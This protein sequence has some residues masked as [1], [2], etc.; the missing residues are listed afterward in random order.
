MIWD[1]VKKV[2]W[3]TVANIATSI[4]LIIAVLVFAWEVYK[5]RFSN[6]FEIFNKLMDTYQNIRLKSH[7]VWINISESVR[8]N[9]KTKH[10]LPD[11]TNSAKYLILRT[12]QTEPLYA[13]EHELVEYE[14]QSINI[15][16]EICKFALKHDQMSLLTKATLSSEI[17]FYQRNLN[18]WITI[19]KY[20]TRERT[21]SKLKY[22]SLMK[23]DVGDFFSDHEIT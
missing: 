22:E 11:K 12:K 23:I 1:L 9:P 20:A 8:S 16:N 4:T 5:N 6:D 18:D 13:I 2:N 21:L 17:S 10:E 3:E 19:R 14:L 15:L 7:Q